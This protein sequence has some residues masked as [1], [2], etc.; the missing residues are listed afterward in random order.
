MPTSRK[1]LAL[2]WTAWLFCSSAAA[3]SHWSFEP[4]RPVEIPDDPSGWSAAPVD[5]FIAEAHRQHR[6]RPQPPAD[7]VT[8]LRRV[9]FDLTGLPPTPQ[10]IE[11][12]LA[13]DS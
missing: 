4:V 13:D 12:F 2:A 8:L 7:R 5:R 11:N 9:T 3:Q 10:E 6:L 1:A